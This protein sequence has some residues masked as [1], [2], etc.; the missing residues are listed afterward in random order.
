MCKNK[1]IVSAAGSGKTTYLVNKALRI[2]NE[3]VLITTYTIANE[4]E[5]RSKI[6]EKN[7]CIPKNIK[8]QTWFSFLLQHGVKPY[9]S[10]VF[11]EEIT[12]INL[13]NSQSVRYIS[14]AN[15]KQHYFDISNRLFSDKISKFVCKC[16]DISCGTVIN[17][18]SRIFPHIY[19]DE[20]QDLAGYDL[21]L[22]NLLFNSNSKILMVGDPR[23]GT[24]STN[25]SS[26]YRKYKKSGITEFFI[27]SENLDI[28]FITLTKNYR[29]NAIICNFSNQ[30]FPDLELSLSGFDE[31]TEHDGLF[32]IKKCDVRNYLS[33][34]KPV[35]LRDKRSVAV[36][37]TFPSMNFGESKGLTFNRILVYPTMPMLDWIF[38]NACELKPI[39]RSKFY[40]AITRARH[41]VG[42]VY[43]Y[44]TATCI[45]SITNY[46]P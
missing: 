9:Q 10:K 26:K 16:N 33:K 8:I 2:V 13:V 18:L 6:I 44:T 28:D 30:L 41:S 37:E 40:V 39:S 27:N 31:T 42:I 45:D 38:N 20:I 3:N 1:L 5:I 15:T 35:Q 25:N 34:Y 12:G 19:I 29:S 22:L 24:Y 11:D 46:L 14:E 4:L 17:R 21:D 36:D 43:D 23:Q 7:K 32:F